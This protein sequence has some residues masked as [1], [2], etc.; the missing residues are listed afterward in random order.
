MY[1]GPESI[2]EYV[3]SSLIRCGLI[4]EEA[5]YGEHH[6]EGRLELVDDTGRSK[7][8]RPVPAKISSYSW[9]LQ[10][11]GTILESNAPEGERGRPFDLFSSRRTRYY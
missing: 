2:A 6:S 11:N 8:R 9:T 4:L 5:A 3:Q 7:S 1:G 10:A